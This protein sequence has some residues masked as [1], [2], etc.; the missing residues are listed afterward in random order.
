MP[1]R[2]NYIKWNDYFMQLAHLTSKRSKDPNTQVGSVIISPDN[3]IIGIG[4]NGF[5]K[6]CSDDIFSWDKPDKYNYVIHAETNALLNC[7]NFNDIKGCILYTTLFPC[8]TCTTLIIQL[9]ISKIIYDSDK[10][11][12]EKSFIKSREMLDHVNIPYEKFNYHEELIDHP[13][14]IQ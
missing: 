10:Y 9:G 5:P 13:N 6:G 2:N 1:K 3:K 8:A 4:Y 7:H 11:H 12:E 14:N